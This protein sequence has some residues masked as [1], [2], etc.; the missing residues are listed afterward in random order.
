MEQNT[1]SFFISFFPFFKIFISFFWNL[2][3]HSSTSDFFRTLFF[4]PTMFFWIF[5]NNGLMN[6]FGPYFLPNNGFLDFFQ[7]WINGFFPDLIFVQQLALCGI[8]SRMIFVTSIF[9]GKNRSFG[10]SWFQFCPP[11][12]LISF[13]IL[14]EDK[15]F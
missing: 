14:V 7:Q 3:F 10:S 4:C 15:L 2:E 13:W 1:A 6:F 12:T 9:S 5:S 8:F 11:V